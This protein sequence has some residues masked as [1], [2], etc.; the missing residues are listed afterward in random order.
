[1]VKE[2]AWKAEGFARAV[3]DLIL[4]E[5]LKNCFSEI[6]CA[7]PSWNF[8]RTLVRLD[9]LSI[10]RQSSEAMVHDTRH[11]FNGETVNLLEKNNC[12][13]TER[14]MRTLLRLETTPA[15]SFDSIDIFPGPVV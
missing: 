11:W 7:K 13:L 10:E 6:G 2:S 1:M 12:S 8:R 14:S 4:A 5:L 15:T 3:A 9:N